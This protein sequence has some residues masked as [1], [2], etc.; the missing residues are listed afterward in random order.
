MEELEQAY[1]TWKKKVMILSTGLFDVPE[2][3]DFLEV[4]KKDIEET[5]DFFIK[6]LRKGPNNAVNALPILFPDA[7]Y[8]EGYCPLEDICKFWLILL[9]AYRDN[10]IKIFTKE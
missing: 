10:L 8:N 5:I 2:W 6:L 4:C 9:I 3:N 1:E 7:A